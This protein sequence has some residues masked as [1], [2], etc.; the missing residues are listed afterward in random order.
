MNIQNK[1]FFNYFVKIKTFKRRTIINIEQKCCRFRFVC[2]WYLQKSWGLSSKLRHW[3][4]QIDADESAWQLLWPPTGFTAWH[5]CC[6][7]GRGKYFQSQYQ[8]YFCTENPLKHVTYSRYC[9]LYISALLLLYNWIEYIYFL[10][11]VQC[12]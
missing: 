9:I 8:I 6:I 3:S 1:Q 2:A 7:P 10:Y 4:N 12:C 11:I 5:N